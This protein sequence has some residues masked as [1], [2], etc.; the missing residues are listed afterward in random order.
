MPLYAYHCDRCDTKFEFWRTF[1]DPPV[2]VCPDCNTVSL[3]KLFAPT[4]VHFKGE[5]W[6]VKDKYNPDAAHG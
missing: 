1:D 6:Y 2:T 4:P 3:R 5:G